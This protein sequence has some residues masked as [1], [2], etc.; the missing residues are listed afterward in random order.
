MSF[1]HGKNWF[2]RRTAFL[3]FRPLR[4]PPQTK[5]V[6]DSQAIR[7]AAGGEAERVVGKGPPE[8]EHVRLAKFCKALLF[9][10]NRSILDSR[11]MWMCLFSI[12]SPFF[13]G[14]NRATKRNQPFQEYP[15]FVDTPHVSQVL[16]T[17]LTRRVFFCVR[18]MHGQPPGCL[19]AVR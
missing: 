7:Q 4:P 10:T 1:Y 9:C 17:H 5:N 15:Y 12:E 14:F 16:A 8:V 11:V 19:N 13:S 2:R 6:T 18:G 3:S